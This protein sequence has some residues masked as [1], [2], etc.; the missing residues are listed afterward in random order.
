MNPAKDATEPK[1][2]LNATTNI[3]EAA[4]G[5]LDEYYFS[6]SIHDNCQKSNH[7]TFQRNA[8]GNNFQK[9]TAHLFSKP[10]QFLHELKNTT[11][12]LKYID[13]P[14]PSPNGMPAFEN[15]R[16]FTDVFKI[17]KCKSDN[18]DKTIPDGSGDRVEKYMATLRHAFLV[19]DC[20]NH[21]ERME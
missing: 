1:V 13:Q 20:S 21:L 17:V 5:I 6:I 8:N 12:S 19:C 18:Q 7:L 15:C 11:V 14:V 2:I 4:L 9:G 16:S 10:R 3:Q